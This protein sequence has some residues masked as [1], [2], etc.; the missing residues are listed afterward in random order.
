M[1]LRKKEFRQWYSNKDGCKN[2]GL[3]PEEGNMVMCGM[4]EYEICGLITGISNLSEMRLCKTCNV[5]QS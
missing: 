3:W 1:R 4:N 5:Q 2:V